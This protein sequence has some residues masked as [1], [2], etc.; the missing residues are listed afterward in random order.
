MGDMATP[1]LEY[2][3]LEWTIEGLFWSDEVRESNVQHFIRS[4][5]FIR[6][7][8]CVVQLGQSSSG[9]NSLYLMP[10]RISLCFAVL[11]IRGLPEKYGWRDQWISRF[12]SLNSMPFPGCRGV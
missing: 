3:K 12:S 5:V 10:T 2:P 4:S 11:D 8:S 1:V 7:L 6:F 9:L